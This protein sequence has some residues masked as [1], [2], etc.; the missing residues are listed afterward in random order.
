M[1]LGWGS[2]R[3]W[4]YFSGDPFFLSRYDKHCVIIAK[5]EYSWV[6]NK[7][8]TP[9]RQYSGHN[10]PLG[11]HTDRGPISLVSVTASGS[12][13]ALILHPLCTWSNNIM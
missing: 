2:I 3:G 12:I 4:E 7:K 1:K 10:T 5:T 9:Q 6:V 8:E 11:H 13:V